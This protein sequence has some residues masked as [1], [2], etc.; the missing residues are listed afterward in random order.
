MFKRRNRTFGQSRGD[1]RQLEDRRL[2]AGNVRVAVNDG[3]IFIRGDNADNVVEAVRVYDDI[4]D[5]FIAIRGLDGTT[6]NGGSE[7]LVPDGNVFVPIPGNDEGIY[8]G[9]R[10]NLGQGDDF[11]RFEGVAVGGV[12]RFYGGPG[13]DSVSFFQSSFED[14]T[15]QTYTG[16]DSISLDRVLITG[17]LRAF[18]LAG[19]DTIGLS[20]VTVTGGSD[21]R[22][23]L[24]TEQG[25]DR[26][27][28]R[29]SKFREL[30]VF[31]GDGDDFFGTNSS[32]ADA[33]VFTGNGNDQVSLFDTSF[34][35]GVVAGQGSDGDGLVVD[36]ERGSGNLRLPGFEGLLEDGA[37]KTQGVLNDQILS[38]VGLGTVAEL[39]ALDPQ[40]SVVSDAFDSFEPNA[41]DGRLDDTRAGV[42][43]LVTLFAPTNAAFAALPGGLLDSLSRDELSDILSFHIGVGTE[44]DLLPSGRTDVEGLGASLSDLEIEAAEEIVTLL[45]G[46]TID[47]DLTDEGVVLDSDAKLVTTNIRAKNGVVHVIDGVLLP[48]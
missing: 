22:A 1:Y 37:E 3:S 7:I 29:F 6:I 4:G 10:V 38:G 35:K 25:D 30:A 17:D 40:L 24:S 18:T 21:V 23:V 20:E 32:T 13:N 41:F 14:L 9:F 43:E 15:V 27:S 26:I 5:S 48:G 33:Q 8:N 12:S 28:L 39:I 16:D 47:V 36:G 19:N 11:M 31:T 44:E 42:D 2:L 45:Q 46:S 34:F